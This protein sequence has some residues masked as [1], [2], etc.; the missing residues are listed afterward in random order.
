MGNGGSKK[1]VISFVVYS[2]IAL[3]IRFFVF[4]PELMLLGLVEPGE[5]LMVSLE[6]SIF[7]RNN[8]LLRFHWYD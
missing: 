7:A 5:D 1:D 4:W 8:P 2:C 6:M 3:I